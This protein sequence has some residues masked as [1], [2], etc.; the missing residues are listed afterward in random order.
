M[1]GESQVNIA[2]QH[3]RVER[4]KYFEPKEQYR[5]SNKQLDRQHF[6]AVLQDNNQV[7]FSKKQDLDTHNEKCPLR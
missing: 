6:A 5:I 2:Q 3:S 1:I 7:L 4:C